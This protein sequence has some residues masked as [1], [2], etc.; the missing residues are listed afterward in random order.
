MIDPKK[1]KELI[2]LEDI[3]LLELDRN[4]CRE[5]GKVIKTDLFY[6]DKCYDELVMED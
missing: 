3:N 4:R 5:C 1:F 2:K 6:C